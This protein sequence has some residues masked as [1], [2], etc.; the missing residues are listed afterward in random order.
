MRRSGRVDENQPEI[1]K[2]LRKLGVTVQPLS[3]V[4][5]GCPDI[6]CGYRGVN[7]LIEI[8]NPLKPPNQRQL[9]KD[10]V[11]WHNL[12]RGQKAVCET[13][14]E[15]AAVVTGEGHES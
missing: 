8:K 15:A 10:Q 4:G 7:T 14:D 12:W 1:I 9:T 3:A 2:Q 6:L 11:T 13:F 5:G